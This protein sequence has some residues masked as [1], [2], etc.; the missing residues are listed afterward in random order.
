MRQGMMEFFSF[1]S[2]NLIQV[3]SPYLEPPYRGIFQT[4]F[5]SD[6]FLLETLVNKPTPKPIFTFFL[7]SQCIL[8]GGQRGFSSTDE[9]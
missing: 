7:S 8:I 3:A 5:N 4:T 9:L 6:F 1:T 2:S